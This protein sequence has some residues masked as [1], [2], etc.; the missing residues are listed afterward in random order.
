[1]PGISTCPISPPVSTPRQRP[2]APVRGWP[3]WRRAAHYLAGRDRLRKREG[4]PHF[5]RSVWMCACA[6]KAARAESRDGRSAACAG[7]RSGAAGCGP[8]RRTA[9]GATT[10]PESPRMCRMT[11]RRS[12]SPRQKRSGAER[13]RGVLPGRKW[14]L[15]ATW[16]VPLFR[17]WVARRGDLVDNAPLGESSVTYARSNLTVLGKGSSVPLRENTGVFS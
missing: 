8:R 15:R 6:S 2:A 16:R 14:G 10:A 13:R 7:S 9:G 4:C 5:R 3:W 17:C 12:K 1:M 11:L